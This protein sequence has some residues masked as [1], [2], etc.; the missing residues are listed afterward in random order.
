MGGQL[1]EVTIFKTDYSIS[2][3][4]WSQPSAFQR[5]WEDEKNQETLNNAMWIIHNKRIVHH[6]DINI[7][8]NY[9]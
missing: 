3:G 2:I 8:L 6:S 4:H 7:S 5:A 9:R 1:V